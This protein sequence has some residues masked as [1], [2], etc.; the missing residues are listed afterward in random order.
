MTLDGFLTFWTLIVAAYTIASDVTRLR[1]RL[2][3]LW[4][5]AISAVGFLIVVYLEIFVSLAPKCGLG[6][7]CRFLQFGEDDLHKLAFLVVAAWMVIITGLSQRK[8]VS[9]GGMLT[10]RRLVDELVYER[11]YAELIQVVEPVLPLLDRGARRQ[12]LAAQV[13]DRLIYGKYSPWPGLLSEDWSPER[14]QNSLPLGDGLGPRMRRALARILPA[15]RQEETAANDVLRV[16]FQTQPLVEFIARYRPAFAIAALK[17]STLGV[18][19]F[20]D[21]LFRAL[22]S[23]ITG[24]LYVEI[25]HNR[26][27]DS[28][29]AYR[30]PARNQLLN[31]LFSDASSADRLRVWEPV[32]GFMTIQLDPIQNAPYVKWLNGSSNYPDREARADPLFVGLDFFDLMITSAAHQ[33]IRSNMSI[34]SISF[35]VLQLGEIYDVQ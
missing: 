19:E 11:R 20:S 13:Y 8:G 23:D 22:M 34:Y 5:G 35:L 32:G 10:L 7:I 25:E 21:R 2:H 15:G 24:E 18:R 14:W 29:F 30:F 4:P 12:L 9:P 3:L 1:M 6:K 16:L 17:C 31:F 26:D 33:G 27:R 28:N